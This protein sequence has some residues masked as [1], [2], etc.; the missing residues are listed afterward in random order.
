MEF[1]R[2]TSLMIILKVIKNQGFN[3][4]RRGQ[5]EQ[6]NTCVT[7]SR[8]LDSFIQKETSVQVFSYKFCKIL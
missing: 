3:L 5:V 7:D 6:E 1:A 4:S 8:F 2:K